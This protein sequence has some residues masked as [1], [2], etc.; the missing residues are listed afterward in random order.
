MAYR[1]SQARGRIRARA[2][3]LRHS[4]SNVGSEPRLRLTPQLTATAGSILNSLSEARD[5]TCVLMDTSQIGFHQAT[6]GTPMSVTFI[7]DICTYVCNVYIWISED[8]IDKNLLA[9]GW[10]NPSLLRSCAKHFSEIG[11][12]AY[13]WAYWAESQT[14]TAGVCSKVK[15]LLQAFKQGS[16]R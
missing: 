8:P 4:H 13:S 11:Q 12:R 10:T 16:G 1:G 14:L 7:V 3:S 15:G 2:A 9:H 6:T 5:Q